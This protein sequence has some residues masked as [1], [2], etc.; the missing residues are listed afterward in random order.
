MRTRSQ[1][2]VNQVFDELKPAVEILSNHLG[3]T[4]K[5]A[6]EALI[7]LVK[8]GYF[9]GPREPTNSMLA[10]YIRSYGE[11]PRNPETVITAVGKAKRRWKA[12]AAEG[13]A[14]ALSLRRVKDHDPLTSDSTET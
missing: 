1:F 14:M 5:E 3:I 10:A 2:S 9:L 11:I 6:Q 13:T 4:K 8:E 7:T 12:M